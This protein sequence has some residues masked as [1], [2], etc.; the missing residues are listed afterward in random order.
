M[1]ISIQV[2]IDLGYLKNARRKGKNIQGNNDS[3]EYVTMETVKLV[4]EN[5]RDNRGNH[6]NNK[7]IM[8]AASDQWWVPQ[9]HI[10]AIVFDNL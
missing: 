2:G 10:L 5:K 7:E 9:F 6:D 1:T 4:T 8:G 3:K